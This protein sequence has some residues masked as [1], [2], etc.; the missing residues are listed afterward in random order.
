MVVTLPSH[1]C[2]VWVTRRTTSIGR[3]VK[4]SLAG[5]TVE[6]LHW[7]RLRTLGLSIIMLLTAGLRL[8]TIRDLLVLIHV[9]YP[10]RISLLQLKFTTTTILSILRIM[11]RTCLRSC[12]RLGC[13]R[14]IEGG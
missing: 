4:S 12:V 3:C 6:M 9:H 2:G 10:V 13:I 5:Y 14:S 8:T 7:V 11:V 1:S